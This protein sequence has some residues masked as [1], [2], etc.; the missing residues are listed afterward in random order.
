MKDIPPPLGLRWGEG[1]SD[2][3]K[4]NGAKIIVKSGRYALLS[5][6]N[7]PVKIPG[8]EVKGLVNDKYGLVKVE[9]KKDII[10]DIYGAEGVELYEKYKKVLEGKYGKPKP[11]YEYIGRS[12]YKEKDEFYQCLSYS[13]CG[14]Y[15]SFFFPVKDSHMTISLELKGER[16]GRGR[17]EM[18]YE[19]QA[20]MNAKSED[21]NEEKDAIKNGL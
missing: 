6:E 7:T 13:G 8:F 21:A 3:T 4:Y 14:Q 20:F 9:I 16:R 17:L 10:D 2:L 1:I 15:I 11:S 12:L 18:V 19:S 5:I